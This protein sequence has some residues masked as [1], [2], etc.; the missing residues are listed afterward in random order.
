MPVKRS[1]SRAERG[2]GG[3]PA[4]CPWCSAAL[5]DGSVPT[6]PS[7]GAALRQAEDAEIPGVTRVDPELIRRA[8][9][10]PAPRGRG[11]VGWL[12]G[13]PAEE[14]VEPAADRGTFAPPPIEVRLEMLHLEREALEAEAQA[15][16]AEVA[17][18]QA[19]AAS[20]AGTAAVGPAGPAEPPAAP[21]EP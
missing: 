6:C 4:I 10:Q 1:T 5:P 14:A 12:T 15:R 20:C 7:C 19:A 2:Q 8:S 11:F 18:E 9:P 21:S 3:Q 17:V 16:A 13:E